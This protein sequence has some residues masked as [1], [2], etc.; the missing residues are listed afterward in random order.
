M[1]LICLKMFD[2]DIQRNMSAYYS[3]S[4]DDRLLNQRLP[5]RRHLSMEPT[6][7]D[8]LGA[9]NLLRDTQASLMIKANKRVCNLHSYITLQLFAASFS[10]A[11]EESSCCCIYLQHNIWSYVNSCPFIRSF[12][13]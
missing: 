13:F 9:Q 11:G 8:I 12:C 6:D 7:F 5:L 10:Y 1:L 2:Q 4:S 3:S